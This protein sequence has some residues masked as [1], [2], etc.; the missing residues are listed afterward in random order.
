MV[1]TGSLTVFRS[2]RLREETAGQGWCR[3]TV[4]TDRPMAGQALVATLALMASLT[5]S[6]LRDL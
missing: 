4:V 1:A 5:V 3:R 2:D 6:P